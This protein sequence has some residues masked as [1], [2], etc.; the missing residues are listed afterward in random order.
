MNKVCLFSRVSTGLQDLSSQEQVLLDAAHKDG[1][2]DEDIIVISEQESA[3]KNSIEDRIG[4]TKAKEA[5]LNQGV[6]TIYVY[7][8]SRIARRLDVF[9]EFRK[10]LLEH[11][12]QLKVLNPAVSLLNDSGE[13]DDNFSLV[14]SIFASLAEQEA[15]LLKG[16]LKRGK[17]K[18]SAMNKFIGG[19]IT[20]GYTRDENDNYCIEENEAKVVRRIFDEYVE[21]NKTMNEIGTDMILDG[22]IEMNVRSARLFVHRTLHNPCYY[23]AEIDMKTYKRRYPAIISK[24]TFDEACKKTGYNIN[25]QKKRSQYEYLCRGLVYHGEKTFVACHST[26]TFNC[27]IKD[28]LTGI[29]MLSINITALDTLVWEFVK[30]RILNAPKKDLEQEKYDL[31]SRISAVSNVIK[32][33]EKKVS[34]YDDQIAK[35]EERIIRGKLTEVAADKIEKTIEKEQKEVKEAL[36]QKQEEKESLEKRKLKLDKTGDTI[37]E[38]DLTNLSFAQKRE[39]VLQNV[40]RIDVSKLSRNHRLVCIYH[41]FADDGTSFDLNAYTKT[42]EDI[43]TTWEQFN[44]IHNSSYKY[45]APESV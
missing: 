43:P 11:R 34:D 26:N 5:I 21:Q 31:S 35:I 3:V 45:K 10:F 16:R 15:R 20:Y 7:E 24:S 39:Y 28:D 18:K 41:S 9:Y 2:K 23:G 36:M 40:E 22:T 42:W 12:V 33:L 32:T 17:A 13:I 8:L 1:I 30:N 27:I 29:E 37:T 4:L 38:E 44:K 25:S 14:F 19:T 6:K